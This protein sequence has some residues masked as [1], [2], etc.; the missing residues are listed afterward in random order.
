MK[1]RFFQ[2]TEKL[3]NKGSDPI[4]RAVQKHCTAPEI[5]TVNFNLPHVDGVLDR[6]DTETSRSFRIP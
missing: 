6:P 2:I 1:I 3:E 5:L 4:K